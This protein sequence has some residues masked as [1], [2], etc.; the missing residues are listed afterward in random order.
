MRQTR[1]GK[2]W[3]F[4][5]KA[6]VGTDQRGIVHSPVTT[7]ANGADINQLP[8][9]EEKELFGDQAYGSEFHRQCT[10]QAGVR[11][12]VNRRGTR[13]R[14]LG[15]HQKAIDRLRSKARTRG[16]HAFC[17]AK[18]L[19]GFGRVRYRG[20]AKNTARLFTAF[21]LANLYLLRRR[22]VPPGERCVL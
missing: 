9:G 22:L 15:E 8:H 12:R 4:G 17:G 1:K 6:H 16:E 7:P 14:P 2:A 11:Y 21:A 5:I 13:T 20:L 19:P 18:R 3:H 10:K